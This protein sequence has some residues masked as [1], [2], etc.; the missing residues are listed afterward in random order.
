MILQID[1][2]K[3]KDLDYNTL[4]ACFHKSIPCLFLKTVCVKETQ[5]YFSII[6]ED[7]KQQNNIHVE[8]DLTLNK[9][10]IDYYFTV[11]RQCNATHFEK[12]L[13]S[14]R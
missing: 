7:A 2:L 6:K 4:Q 14:L 3:K 12:K 13:R 8:K 11:V 9:V 5:Q 1:I 10:T